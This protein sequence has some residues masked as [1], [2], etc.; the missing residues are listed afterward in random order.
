MILSLSIKNYA[1]IEDIRVDLDNGLTI[2]TGETGAG[3]SILLGALSLLMGK[4]A[5]SSSVKNA[6]IKCIIEGEFSLKN[7]NLSGVFSDND[8][9]YDAHTIIR[10]EILP[11]GK[12]R[13]FVNDTPVSLNQ[14][15]SLGEHLV[16]IHSQNETRSFASEEFQF[17]VLDALAGNFPILNDYGNLLSEYNS[18]SKELQ[19]QT[20]LKN[21]ALKELDYNS[22]L[23]SELAE[24][25]LTKLNQEELE[26]IFNTLD[27]AET[28]E[29]SF[30]SLMQLFSHEEIGTI[31][32]AKE[33]R[34]VI[35]KISNF[36]DAYKEIHERLNSIV[37]ELEDIFDAV[38]R[39]SLKVEA[40]PNE[41]ATVN[42]RL[43]I[44]YK[45]QQKHNVNTVEELIIIENELSSK[46]STTLHLDTIIEAM[47]I[48]KKLLFN[49]LENIAEKLHKKRKSAVP[50]FLQKI[51]VYLDMLGLP[52][53]KFDFVFSKVD[54]FKKNG[55]DVLQVNF[56]ANKGSSL[57]PLK[58]VA[59][60]GE[61]SRIML[62]VKAVLAKYRKLPTLVFDEIDTGVS[63][64][65]ALKMATIMGGMSKEMQLI[66]ITHLPQIAS[67]GAQH[68]KVF[69]EDVNNK[70]ITQ[71][72][73]LTDEERIVEIAQMIS[74]NKI[75]DTALANAREL[76][77]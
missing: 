75:T 16:D 17:E 65:V 7:Y 74:G 36:T 30:A 41:L 18:V 10:R 58:K 33:A 19:M 53:A 14:L 11:S 68:I 56:T 49:K 43:Q 72:Q 62:S 67:K 21:E 29:E 76:L 38:E 77:N 13:A 31:E 71:M 39:A 50:Q 60:G 32:T 63:G 34:G 73:R 8:L 26:A 23:Q 59:S 61:M 5:D 45:L 55:T 37:I 1:L 4:R 46:I 69:K 64:E 66:S 6:S 70:T 24:A 54:S 22:F 20:E 27:N 40:D 48:E 15:Q 42:E 2:I 3:K 47:I 12:S 28:I 35:G 57:G 51:K 44:L 52:N 25:N 9:D